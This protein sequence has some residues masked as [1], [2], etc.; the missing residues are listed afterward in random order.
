MCRVSFGVDFCGELCLHFQ[1][2]GRKFHLN[3][4]FADNELVQDEEGEDDGHGEGE[5]AKLVGV[6]L[7]SL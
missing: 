5:E 7:Y 2:G 4:T 6:D 1:W 3:I